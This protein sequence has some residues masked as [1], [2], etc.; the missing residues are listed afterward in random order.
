MLSLRKCSAGENLALPSCMGSGG[1]ES[2]A[3][4]DS[5]G[6]SGDI[7]FSRVLPGF[8]G[9]APW[10][11]ECD[12]EPSIAVMAMSESWVHGKLPGC[13]LVFDYL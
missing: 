5:R 3:L 12:W 2:I 4:G 1:S 7:G 13:E 8:L 10:T 6:N 9:G 11:G